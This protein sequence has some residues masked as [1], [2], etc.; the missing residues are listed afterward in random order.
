MKFKILLTIIAFH[1]GAVYSTVDANGRV[2]PD[3]I[4]FINDT[5]NDYLIGLDKS[6]TLNPTYRIRLAAGATVHYI[7]NKS[8]EEVYDRHNGWMIHPSMIW[9]ITFPVQSQEIPNEHT[10][11]TFKLSN[12]KKAQIKNVFKILAASTV[13]IGGILCITPNIVTTFQQVL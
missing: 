11:V 2:I 3:E 8:D 1:S 13:C 9:D 12:M 10:K 5:K 6:Q 4:V 7:V